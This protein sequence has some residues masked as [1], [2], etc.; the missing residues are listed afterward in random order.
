M[1]MSSIVQDAI[2]ENERET[3]DSITELIF[4]M[5]E[6]LTEDATQEGGNNYIKYPLAASKET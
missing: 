4:S 5:T 1:E 3:G 6:L 2:R